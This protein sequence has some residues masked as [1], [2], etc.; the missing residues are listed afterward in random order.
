MKNIFKPFIKLS[1]HINLVQV[2]NIFKTY[3]AQD[4]T[5]ILTF[6]SCKTVFKIIYLEVFIKTCRYRNKKYILRIKINL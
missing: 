2:L 5:P 3:L 6:K 4:E 1:A